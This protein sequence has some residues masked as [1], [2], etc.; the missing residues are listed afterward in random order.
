[1]VKRTNTAININNL[2][3]KKSC[4]TGKHRTAGWNIPVGYLIDSGKMSAMGCDLSQGTRGMCC[5]CSL[6]KT[7]KLILVLSDEK[8]YCCLCGL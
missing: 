6:S 4:H 7:S 2:K 5:W 3:G 8:V 1:M